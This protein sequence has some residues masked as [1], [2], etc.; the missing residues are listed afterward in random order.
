MYTN[1]LFVLLRIYFAYNHIN[2]INYNVFELQLLYA[3]LNYTIHGVYVIIYAP[4]RNDYLSQLR[5]AREYVIV[6]IRSSI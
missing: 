3:Q 5:L 2:L 1:V 6:A 4:K